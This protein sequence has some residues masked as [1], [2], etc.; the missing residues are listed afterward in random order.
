MPVG[1]HSWFSHNAIYAMSIQWLGG[2][3]LE[4]RVFIVPIKWGGIRSYQEFPNHVL[5]IIMAVSQSWYV[6][7]YYCSDTGTRASPRHVSVRFNRCWPTPSCSRTRQIFS[8]SAGVGRIGC[9]RFSAVFE[10]DLLPLLN[11]IR[12]N[13]GHE[14]K[15]VGCW[16]L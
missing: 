15:P 16:S 4:L 12:G 10:K 5:D 9:K 11:G 6:M 1:I 8:V 14:K 2:S 7:I 13:I 3:D